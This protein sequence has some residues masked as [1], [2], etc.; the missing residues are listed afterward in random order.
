MFLS[1]WFMKKV[2]NRLFAKRAK[3][4][5]APVPLDKPSSMSDDVTPVDT[6]EEILN[7]RSKNSKK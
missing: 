4:L 7:A 2:W 5:P 3:V 1:S 6:K